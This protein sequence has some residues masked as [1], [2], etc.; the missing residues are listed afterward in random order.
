MLTRA[1]ACKARGSIRPIGRGVVC[2][3][4]ASDAWFVV[5]EFA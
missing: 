3:I 5:C 2:A 4:R 1:A